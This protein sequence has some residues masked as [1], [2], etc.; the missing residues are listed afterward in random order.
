MYVG[1]GRGI[2]A[3]MGGPGIAPP[4]VVSVRV[5]GAGTWGIGGVSTL[6]RCEPGSKGS[7]NVVIKLNNDEEVKWQMWSCLY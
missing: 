6:G 4:N 5:G 1:R 7:L 2:D 3:C